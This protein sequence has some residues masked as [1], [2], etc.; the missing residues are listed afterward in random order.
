MARTTIPTRPHYWVKTPTKCPSHGSKMTTDENAH[1]LLRGELLLDGIVDTINLA[2]IHSRVKQHY[3]SA[4]EPELINATVETI[5]A[6]IDDDL[7]EAGYYGDNGKFTPAPL[8]QWMRE[9]TDAYVT[10]HDD[11]AEW[12]FSYW[13]NLT[14]KGR[15]IALSTE[16]GKAV[17]RHERERIAGLRAAGYREP[18]DQRGAQ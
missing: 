8:D 12:V 13:L 7:M 1:Q 16:Q 4:S 14:D 17:D 15:R 6:L 3:P 10:H 2:G 5:R 11:R 18:H 9:L